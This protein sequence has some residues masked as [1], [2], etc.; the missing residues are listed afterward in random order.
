MKKHP[1]DKM[2]DGTPFGRFEHFMKRLVAVP[3][4]AVTERKEKKRHKH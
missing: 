4:E 2:A 1:T 3:K